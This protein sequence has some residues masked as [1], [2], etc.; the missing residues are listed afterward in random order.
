MCVVVAGQSSAQGTGDA[1][2]MHVRG[3]NFDTTLAP[4]PELSGTLGHVTPEPSVLNR[5]IFSEQE[6]ARLLGLPP[7][8][9][10]YWLEGG[11]RR[12]KT[13]APVLRVEP[14]G[15][16]WVTWAEFIEAG[17]LSTYRRTK[18][19]PLPELRSFICHL[20]DELGV[21]YPLAH[22]RPLVCG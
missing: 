4:R 20:R 5:E 3:R 7:S 6:A 19:V 8:T 13:Y 22:S 14:T 16:R 15:S 9:L 18:G 1:A 10:H 21:P 11:V 2:P 12:G 17:W